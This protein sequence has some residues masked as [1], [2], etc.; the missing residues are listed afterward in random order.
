[1]ASEKNF[2]E[3]IVTCQKSIVLP[4]FYQFDRDAHT[5]AHLMLAFYQKYISA[6]VELG[7]EGLK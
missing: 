2:F 3:K 5:P 6:V 1:M 7:A 4:A